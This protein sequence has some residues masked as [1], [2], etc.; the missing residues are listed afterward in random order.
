MYSPFPDLHGQTIYVDGKVSTNDPKKISPD[1]VLAYV[2]FQ[3]RK[4]IRESTLVKEIMSLEKLLLFAENS[5]VE[6]FRIKYCSST[7]KTRRIRYA[8]LKERECDSILKYSRTVTNDGV[9]LRSYVLVGLALGSGLRTKELQFS[10]LRNLDTRDWTIY[11][12]RVKGEG[13]Y[14][15][16]AIDENL[17][18][19]SV[20]LLLGHNTTKTTESYYCRKRPDK[21]V[22]EA[23]KMGVK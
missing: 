21:A 7:P 6:T 10:E 12:D 23:L 8:G 19:E 14:G 5:S 2:A 4:E 16:K 13:T 17:P 9:R 22:Q 11:V 20:S 15:Q 3:K 18:P 1:D